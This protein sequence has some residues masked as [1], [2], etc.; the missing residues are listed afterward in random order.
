VSG[1]TVP[2][3]DPALRPAAEHLLAGRSHDRAGR[4]GEAMAAYEAALHL[5]VESGERAAHV[6]ASRRLGV[7]HHRGGDRVRAHELCRRSYVDAIGLGDLALAGEALNAL[8]GFAFEAGE[9][10]TARR[11]WD[12][13]L[14]LAGVSGALHGRIEQNLGIIANVMGDHE[15]AMAHYRRSLNSF[16][17]A[18]D[19]RGRAIAYHNLGKIATQRGELV[20]ADTCF[21]RSAGLATATGD[22]HLEGLCELNRAELSHARQQFGEALR[23]VEAALTIFERLGAPRNK[24]GAY[25]LLGMVYRDTGRPA[26]AEERFRAA[27]ALAVETGCLLDE[28][29]VCRELALLHL[30]Q[31]RNQDALTL[32]NRAHGLF[33]RLD[34][35]V[36]VVDIAARMGGLEETFLAVVR[37]WGQSIESADQYT[38]GHCERVARYAV[39]VGGVLGLD[40]M[41]LT[42]LRLGAYLHDVGKVRVPHEILNKP[43]RLT[44]EEFEIIKLHP[45]HGVELLKGVEFPWDLRPIVRWH[46][47]KQDGTGYPDRL[48]GDEIPLGSQVIGIVDVFDALTTTRSYRASMSRETALAE[49]A[50]CRHWWRADVYDAFMASVGGSAEVWEETV[51]G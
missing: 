1:P 46:H 30:G 19:D 23:R 25:K 37:E 24:S 27:M 38:F 6:E 42:T 17:R 45:V 44:E 26:L 28:A 16:E 48:R 31:G 8:A 39:A 49:L 51:R 33:S 41:E 2:G 29:D 50:R 11:T 20:D 21:E 13:A 5:A 35:R 3:P 34:A 14:S 18:G 4:A 15:A 22:V 40:P 36:D 9:M 7:L 43:G 47:E 10:A 12:H 32:L